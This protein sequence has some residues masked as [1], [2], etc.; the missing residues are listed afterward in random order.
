MDTVKDAHF[1]GSSDAGEYL[2]CD[3]C[4]AIWADSRDVRVLVLVDYKEDPKI[5]ENAPE[6]MEFQYS[7]DSETTRADFVEHVIVALELGRHLQAVGECEEEH[8]LD[9]YCRSRPRTTSVHK[10]Q[11]SQTQALV[12]QN[13]MERVIA[14]SWDDDQAQLT[15]E[16]LVKLPKPQRPVN[17]LLPRNP[18]CMRSLRSP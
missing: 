1:M 18:N 13:F 17:P 2:I 6:A 11:K 7:F 4:C 16:V 12:A 15:F 10:A 5:R 14:L 9:L 3:N 8:E